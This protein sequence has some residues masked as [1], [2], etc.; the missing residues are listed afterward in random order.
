MKNQ[1]FITLGTTLIIL[2]IVFAE[3]QLISY[4]FI[5]AGLFL[6]IISAFKLRR[7]CR[8]QSNRTGGV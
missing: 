5:V 8:I 7:K 1:E 4:S 6:S 2:G 3:E